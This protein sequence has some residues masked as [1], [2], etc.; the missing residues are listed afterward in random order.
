MLLATGLYIEPSNMWQNKFLSEK[1]W[2]DFKNFF[3]EECHDL[4]KLKCINTSQVDFHNSN[5]D[6]TMQGNI[7]EALDNLAM[8]T[9]SEKNVLTQLTSTIKQLAETN[10]TLTDQIKTLTA[11]NVRLAENGRH[12]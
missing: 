10:K 6:I 7:S 4:R 11:K 9:T 8:A 12:Q 1:K 5:T 2:S 3:A